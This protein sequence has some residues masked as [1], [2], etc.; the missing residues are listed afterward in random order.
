MQSLITQ[1]IVVSCSERLPTCYSMEVVANEQGCEKELD[2]KVLLYPSGECR[3]LINRVT[4]VYV[5]EPYLSS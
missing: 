3:V 1:D 5:R 4:R 2:V